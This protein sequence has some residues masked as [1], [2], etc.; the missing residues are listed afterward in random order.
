MNW[1]ENLRFCKLYPHVLNV[2]GGYVNDPRDPGGATKYGVAFNYN[3]GYLKQFG[4]IRP[5]QMASL[6]KDQALEIY[7]RKYWLPSQADELPDSRLSLVYFDHVI[8]AGQGAADPLLAKLGPDL[9]K[10]AGDGKNVNY[11][12]SLSLQLMLHRLLWY[13][14]IKNWGTY[15]KGWFNRLLHISQALAK[16]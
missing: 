11:F 15:G 3:Q 7:Y 8:N 9:W 14:S 12:W 16:V 4:I 1:R 5:E 2:E 10:F 6:T 13:F